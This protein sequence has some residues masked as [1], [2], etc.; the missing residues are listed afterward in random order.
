[1]NI[2]DMFYMRKGE[3]MLKKICDFIVDKGKW[4]LTLFLILTIVFAVLIFQVN[5]NYDMTDYLPKDSPI[6]EAMDTMFTEF[7]DG[8]QA[9]IMIP[10]IVPKGSTKIK[11]LEKVSAINKKIAKVD[12]VVS[13][14]WLDT[15]LEEYYP[16]IKNEKLPIINK[17]VEEYFGSK[18]NF[19]NE[20]LKN[21][22][23]YKGFIPSEMAGMVDMMLGQFYKD[24]NALIQI[25]FKENAY[26]KNTVNAI[27]EIQSIIAGTPNAVTG[28]NYTSNLGG[29]AS[30]AYAMETI[31]E[32]ELFKLVMIVAP[33]IILLLLLFTTSYF[34]P[35]VY[36]VVIGISVVLN[37][38]SNVMMSSVSYLTFSIA[39][40][41][42]VAVSMDYS[43][44]I[45]HSYK[46]YRKDGLMPK[47]AAKIALRKSLSSVSASS[48]TTIAG[49]VALMF[50]RYKIGMDI[51]LVLA[52][53]ILCSLI[54]AFLFMPGFLVLCDKPIMK[55]EHKPIFQAIRDWFIKQGAKRRYKKINDGSMSFETYLP[56][57]MS[58]KKQ[59]SQK[60][61][62]KVGNNLLKLRF[63]VPI[64]FIALLAPAF[65]VQNNNHFMYGEMSSSGG[66]GSTLFTDRDE[67]EAVFGSQN[68]I[69]VLLKNEHQDK[70]INIVHSL[71]KAAHV[72]EG[73]VQSFE[74]IK[75]SLGDLPVPDFM[76]SQFV[77]KNYRMII[78]TVDSAEEDDAAFEA[79]DSIT[80]IMK[81]QNIEGD[82]YIIGN[83]VVA[84]ELRVINKTDYTITTSL[85]LTFIFVILLFTFKGLVLPLIL[86]LLIQGSIWF[87]M[88][89][90][91]FSNM[92]LVFLG[93]LI[94]SCF[95]MGC[96]IDYGILFSNNY[97]RFRETED[98]LTACKHAFKA[99][100]GA[101]SLSAAILMTVGYVVGI[102]GSIPATSNIG[103]L[104]GIGAT[105]SYIS[106]TYLLP[107][108]L[109]LLDKPILATTLKLKRKDK[110][111]LEEK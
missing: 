45:M 6:F 95:Q 71:E 12:G 32:S 103:L 81:E 51:G 42:Q 46:K 37:M 38:G 24:G 68:N 34:E 85:A 77:G 91:A 13:V 82:Y 55:G 107:L 14:L 36:L 16:S 79:V 48:L 41:I 98:K 8:A 39:A 97:L 28:E 40:L 108:F 17:T 22:E 33:I 5:I 93:Y 73:K 4:F 72:G 105:V 67:I 86:A 21:F 18:E 110:V 3:R 62:E 90:P 75:D 84:K 65:M 57:Q 70:E 9:T 80:N 27:K 52:K 25:F 78:M 29:M 11:N 102:A 96:T 60:K 109:V 101:V 87:A 31:M 15:A 74:I 111:K 7:G 59:K 92:P 66:P 50:M 49:F 76:K 53:G 10:D 99:S 69:V 54:T 58:A 20:L 26:S 23:V 61:S 89:I 43:I 56:E 30:S 19:A 2:N 106:M 83:S 88:T 1:M 44:F 63:V 104:L 100:I 35:V 47:D 94:V 64:L